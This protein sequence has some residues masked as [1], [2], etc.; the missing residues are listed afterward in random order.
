MKKNTLEK[1]YQAL[2][3]ESPELILSDDLLSKAVVPIKR[4]LDISRANGFG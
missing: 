1:T 4:M 2:L 3:H